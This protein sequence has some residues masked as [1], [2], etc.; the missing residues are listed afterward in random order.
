MMSV[1][2]TVT[3]LVIITIDFKILNLIRTRTGSSGR[4]SRT[5]GFIWLG[6]ERNLIIDKSN[7]LTF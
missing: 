5:G 2:T 6:N 3:T 1:F 7:N 4:V